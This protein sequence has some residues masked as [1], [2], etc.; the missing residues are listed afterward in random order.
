M[1]GL[2]HCEI[3]DVPNYRP[4]RESVRLRLVSLKTNR[5]TPQAMRRVKRRS[6]CSLSGIRYG[7]QLQ[8]LEKRSLYDTNASR[9]NLI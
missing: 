1:M 7:K 2:A 4:L 9:A 6:E 5:N 3:T 8:M